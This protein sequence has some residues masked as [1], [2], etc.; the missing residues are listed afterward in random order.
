MKSQTTCLTLCILTSVLL[1]EDQLSLGQQLQF[2]G[3]QPFRAYASRSTTPGQVIYQLFAVNSNAGETGGI[4]YSISQETDASSSRHFLLSPDTGKL[5]LSPLLFSSLAEH[6]LIIEA[7]SEAPN[8]A[9]VQVQANLLVVVVAE[10][11]LTPRFERE[12]Y[13]LSLP[14][15]SM[16][17]RPFSVIQ[18][19]PLSPVSSH[20][21]SVIGDTSAGS[22]SINV[23]NGLL[24]LARSLD[25]EK[26]DG[27]SLTIRYSFNNRFI[28]VGVAVCVLDA[29][30]NSPHFGEMI[31]NVTVSEDADLSSSVLRVSAVD[32]DIGSNRALRYSLQPATAD[33]SLDSQTG[34][35]SV[36]SVLDYERVDQYQFTVTAMDGGS[37]PMS[38]EV[39]VI[40]NIGNVDDECP[41]FDNPLYLANIHSSQLVPNMLVL[42]VS[43]R[44][45][46]GFD[47]S[48]VTYAITSSS[49]NGDAFSLNQM[50]GEITITNITHGQYSLN[51]SASD[52]GCSMRSFTWVEIR[53]ID[54]NSHSPMFNTPCNATLL[55]NP[56]LGMEVVILTATDDDNGVNGE[57]TY[58]LL[59]TSYFSIDS[60]SGVVTTNQNSSSYDRETQE[61]FQVGVVA[62]DGGLRQGYCLLTIT[63]LDENDNP[64]LFVLSNLNVTLLAEAP[65][66]IPV[67]RAIAFDP[68]MGA[69][70]ELLYFLSEPVEGNFTV[71]MNTAE[72]SPTGPNAL[73]VYAL[74]LVASDMG[75]PPGQ[76]SSIT[77]NIHVVSGNASPVFNHLYYNT[78]LCENVPVGKTVLLL[79]ASGNPSPTYTLVTGNDYSSN[80][81][82][83]FTLSDNRVRVGSFV[84]VDF[85]RLNFRKS[86]I[87]PVIASNEL[88]SSFTIVEI[89]VVDLDDNP[90]MVDSGYSFDLLEN[91]PIGLVV[92]RILAHDP[93]SGTNGEIAYHLA[94]PSPFFQVSPMGIVTSRHTFDFENTTELLSGELTVEVSNPNPSSSNVTAIRSS[95]GF[96]VFLDSTTRTFSVRWTI[97]NQNDNSPTFSTSTYMVRISEDQPIWTAILNLTA[98]D[99]DVSDRIRLSFIISEEGNDGSF[100]M[101]GNS[102]V[103]LRRLDFEVRERYNITVQVTDGI[104]SRETCTRCTAIVMVIV[105]DVD[106]EP[107]SFSAPSYSGDLVEMVALGTR[108]LMLNAEDPDSMTISYSLMGP[109]SG[110]FEVRNSG[111]IVVSG[112]VDRED[113]PGG[114]ISFL[115][116][117]EGGG[118][119]ATAVVTVSVLDINDHAPRF[120]DVFGGCVQENMVPGDEGIFITQV[121]AQD[122]DDARNGTVTYSLRGETNESGFRINPSTGVITAHAEYDREMQSSHFLIVEAADNGT[123]TALTSSTLVVV[124]I[125]DEND[126]PPFFPF[127]F[128]FARL[129]EDEMVGAHILDI[130]VYDPDEGANTNLIFSLTSSSLSNKFSV[131]PATGEVMLAGTLD[132][133]IPLHRSATLNIGVQDPQF[134]GE[135]ATGVLF[136]SLLDRNDNTPQVDPPDYIHVLGNPPTLSETFPPGPTLVTI[137]ATDEDEG[138]N[139]ELEFSIVSGDDRGDFSITSTGNIGRVTHTRLLDYETTNHYSLLVSVSDHGT[140][141][142]STDVLLEFRVQDINDNPPSFSQPTYR[143]SIQENRPPVGSVLR[144]LAN[145]PDT[146]IG[147]LVGSYRIVSGNVEDRFTMNATTGILSTNVRLDREEMESYVLTITASDEG[148]ESLTGTGTIE[149]TITDV[150]DNPS[151]DGL[152]SVFIYDGGGL[153]PH[154][155]IGTVFFQDPD[156]TS[157][158]FQSCMILEPFPFSDLFG[159]DRDG[160]ILS[161]GSRI[162]AMGQYNMTVRG[163]DGAHTSSRTNITVTVQGIQNGTLS[164]NG[165][166]TLTLNTSAQQ[167]HTTEIGSEIVSLLA[168]NLGVD[169]IRVHLLSLQA[170]FHD[171]LNTVDL[172]FS[173]SQ[174]AGGLV[175]PTEVINRLFLSRSNLFIGQQGVVAIPTDP[176]ITEPCSNQAECRTTR[177]IGSTQL[178]ASSNQYILLAPVVTLGYECICAPGT[179]GEACETNYDD[180]YSQPCLYGAQCTDTVQG[181]LCDCPEGTSG[182]DCSFNP[183]E[184]TSNPCMNDAQCINGFGTYVCECLPG[185]YGRECQYAHFLVAPSCVPNHC[186]NGAT[187]SPGRDTFTCLCPDGFS[188][189]LCETAVQVQ[190]GCVGNPCHNGSSCMDTNEGP[191]CSCSI[192]FTGPQCRWPLNNCELEPCQNGGTCEMGLYGSY[193]CTCASGYTGENCEQRV[194][195]CESS[196]C[197]NGGRCLENLLDGSFTCQC[198]RNYTGPVC[199]ISILPPDLCDSFPL[200]CSPFSNCTSGAMSVTCSCSPGYQGPDCSMMAADASPCASNPCLHGGTCTPGQLDAYT[201]AC[202]RGFSGSNCD[203]NVDDCVSEPCLNGGTC[204]DGIGGYI[205]HCNEGLTGEFCQ[206]FCPEGRVGEFCEMPVQYCSNSSCNNGGTCIEAIGSFAC[207]CPISHTGP[208]CELADDCTTASCFNG[209]TCSILPS[210]V[211]C[212]CSTGFDG[213]NCEL[214]TASFSGS[215]EQNSFRAFQPLGSQ[216]QVSLGLEF[217]TKAQDGLLL[218]STQ[219][220]NEESR[221]MVALEVVGGRLRVSLALGSG[222]ENL[223]V[224]GDSVY[225]SDGQWHQASVEVRGKVRERMIMSKGECNAQNRLGSCVSVG[226]IAWAL[227]CRIV[228]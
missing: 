90:P 37:P 143:V 77:I 182:Q 211:L 152:M 5:H 227:K 129:F 172:T 107:P 203:I 82:N 16:V 136:I 117:A 158:S 159:I 184:C 2:L 221:D 89:F 183:D 36:S 151:Q 124:D 86:F 163:R 220:Q 17:D 123:P 111:E 49:V 74:S 95:C 134:P 171:P 127:P 39:I 29:N 210:G 52:G 161:F 44:D 46:D 197:L 115:A 122:P 12:N 75:G 164:E 160:C 139:G 108:V 150:N 40:V 78:T 14:E 185:Y 223:V 96:D 69:N 15:N 228:A 60:V 116:V 121:M 62:I 88:G 63:L 8:A 148:A 120:L 216:G 93:D 175:P 34:V 206:V 170:G 165:V 103:L 61:V 204:E 155:R 177:T 6:M 126:N 92:T 38:T 119:I 180:C 45:P 101:D 47:A 54:T 81:E 142:L 48:R 105:V 168:R 21:F 4:T 125:G 225:V 66:F 133:E 149:I 57:V 147:G 132:Y 187:C 192:G 106:D 20:S 176:C 131:D 156:T 217:A 59:N 83:T 128:M 104:H 114:V 110:R 179:A 208:Q 199:D 13:N 1:L 85:E 67:A 19:F 28:D 35:L 222:A 214:L 64:P 76:L 9:T 97:S 144:V 137:T 145:D 118:G 191:L 10:S 18:V 138:S 102:I 26:V 226:N 212:E 72:I 100:V 154:M 87:F 27:Y 70:G 99:L 209:G 11:E 50:T 23:T 32:P 42:T 109:A 7:R 31:Y 56:P 84:L 153:R 190:G 169:R 41:V 24:S 202:S 186:Q 51:I 207:I 215:S 112:V 201:C 25:R 157:N 162:P 43:A 91:Q 198:H 140:P 195:A 141:P 135:E 146:D 224:S 22:F 174:E 189:P 94:S 80:S 193:L 200:P 53:I 178:A 196:P 166:M 3:E 98:T 213:P 181:F 73:G 58:S 30:D 167:Y 194:L 33:F 71:N 79:N 130:P 188:G 55:E 65:P 218:F 68:D 219:Y 205:C 113:F 173:V